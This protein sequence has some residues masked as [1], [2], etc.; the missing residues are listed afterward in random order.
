MNVP[1]IVAAGSAEL[2]SVENPLIFSGDGGFGQL[3]IAV[4]NIFRIVITPI[5]VF[6]VIYAGFNFVVGRGNPE[7][8]NKAK[9][10]LVYALIGAVII[11]G[12]EAIGLIVQNTANEFGP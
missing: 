6:F 4:I 3:I 8:I 10:A 1:F 11:A 2:A 9:T 5:I 7:N 12:A